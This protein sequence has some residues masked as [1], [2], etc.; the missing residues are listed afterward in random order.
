MRSPVATVIECTWW[1]LSL[2]HLYTLKTPCNSFYIYIYICF[3][4][5]NP[6]LLM[7]MIDGLILDRFTFDT[8]S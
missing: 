3:D 5:Y 1:Y 7:H 2:G 4:W 6:C 8:Y